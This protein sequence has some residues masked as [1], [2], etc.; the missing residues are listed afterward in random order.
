MRVQAL[1]VGARALDAAGVGRDHHDL[2]AVQALAQVLQQHRHRVQ[3]VD[4]DVEE[5]LDLTGVQVDGQHASRAAAVIR[6]ATSLAVIGV[7]GATLR[8]WRA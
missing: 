8:S 5:A 7:R 6:S 1:G 3:V 4:R 2:A